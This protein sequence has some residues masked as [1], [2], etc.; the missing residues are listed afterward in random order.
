MF[1]Q[2]E[3]WQHPTA[4]QTNWVLPVQAAVVV[5]YNVPLVAFCQKLIRV[6]QPVLLD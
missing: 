2:V 3:V 1:F 6:V 5:E 4:V